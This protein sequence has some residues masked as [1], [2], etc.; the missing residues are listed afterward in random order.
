MCE[1]TTTMPG[2]YPGMMDKVKLTLA[3]LMLATIPLACSSQVDDQPQP[4][5]EFEG[6]I[7]YSIELSSKT[8]G[9]PDKVFQDIYGHVLVLY[10]KHGRWRM[11]FDGD[12]LNEVFYFADENVEYTKRKGI[13]T[14][15]TQKCDSAYR[16]QWLDVSEQRE[17]MTVLDKTCNCVVLRSDRYTRT[18]CYSPTL[19]IDPKPF[20]AYRTDHLNEYYQRARA[21]FLYCKYD[22][23]HFGYVYT[24]T[25]IEPQ[26]L[27]DSVFDLPDLPHTEF[28]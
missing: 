13:D 23:S 27:A 15:F 19:Y 21:P 2:G 11:S 14:L 8:E 20:A 16:E 10:F 6:I 24:A 22:G 9:T 3:S 26:P 1:R 18:L 7:R 12:D 4:A 5:T 28:K 17:A 25:S